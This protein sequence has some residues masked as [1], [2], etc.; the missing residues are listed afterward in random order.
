MIIDPT[1]VGFIGLSDLVLESSDDR[2]I[3]IRKKKG[4]SISMGIIHPSVGDQGFPLILRIEDGED[5]GWHVHEV[6]LTPLNPEE[7]AGFI[8]LPVERVSPILFH[9]EKDRSID[10]LFDLLREKI[11]SYFASEDLKRRIFVSVQGASLDGSEYEA[12]VVEVQFHIH[13]AARH[14]YKFAF[15]SNDLEGYLEVDLSNEDDDV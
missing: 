5:D 3:N 9:H 12:I 13:G 2:I 11:Q 4:V 8:R 6:S 1:D 7:Y 14:S 15:E 10:K